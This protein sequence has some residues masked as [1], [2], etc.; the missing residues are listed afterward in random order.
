M[1][2]PLPSDYLA[3]MR[4]RKPWEGFTREGSE[5]GYVVLWSLEQL[6]EFNADVEIEDYAPGFIGF[7]GNGAGELLAFDSS[8]A[9]FMLPMIGLAPDVAIRIADTF[10]E[11]AGRLA[12]AA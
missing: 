1:T 8:G 10:T 4:H 5:P 7:G 9:V 12:D 11:L 2:V 6:D 3:Y